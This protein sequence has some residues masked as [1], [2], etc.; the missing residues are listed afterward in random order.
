MTDAGII[1]YDLAGNWCEECGHAKSLRLLDILGTCQTCN[2]VITRH[3]CVKLPAVTDR[4]PG[5]DWECPD[6]GSTW[7]LV[8]E[9]EACPDCCSECGH[10]VSRRRWDLEEEGDRIPT[11]PKREPQP[12]TPFRN[13]LYRTTRTLTDRPAY[14]P[15]LGTAPGF[16]PSRPGSCYRAAAGF[17][18]HVRPGCRCPR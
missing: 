4:A 8:Q 1:L 16:V 9:E 15:L 10:A 6:C 14:S 3:R 7:R 12:Y 2:E 18:V 11:A 13:A 17:M 5:Q